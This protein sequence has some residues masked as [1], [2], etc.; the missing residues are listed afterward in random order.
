L[1]RIQNK[2]SESRLAL[3]F[4][5]VYAMAV[6]L[7]QGLWPMQWW[8]HMACFAVSVYLMVE[9]NNINALIRIYSRMISCTFLVLSCVACFVF[10][11]LAGS[12]VQLCAVA[13]YITLF[14]TYQDRLSA[15]WSF[16]TF[17]CIGIGSLVFVHILYFVP[18]IWLLMG[19][20]LH[21]FSWRTF[22]ASLFG[23]LLPYWFLSLYIIYREDITLLTAHFEPLLVFQPLFSYAA[24]SISHILTFAFIAVLAITGIIHYLR[25]SYSDKIRIRMLYECFIILDLAAILFLVLQPQHYD[26]LIRLVI[27]GTAPL[28]GHF[29]ALTRTKLTNIAFCIIV[30]TA[31]LITGYNVWISSSIF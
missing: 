14:H 27:V 6:W 1:K 22:F 10:D 17:L 13:S 20:I 26:I 16:Y 21:S 29:I 24:L 15:G 11:D 30:L 31:L 28:T 7:L 23:L 12:I 25:T 18:V 8:A 4:V 3:P 19:F 5:T 2:I 9:L